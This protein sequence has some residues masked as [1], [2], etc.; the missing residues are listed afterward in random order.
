MQSHSYFRVPKARSRDPSRPGDFTLLRTWPTPRGR[1]WMR[2]TGTTETGQ[3]DAATVT[4]CLHF[5]NGRTGIVSGFEGQ[6]TLRELA[7]Y[8]TQTPVCSTA[9]VLKRSPGL[10]VLLYVGRDGSLISRVL[11]DRNDSSCYPS[12]VA[13]GARH[14]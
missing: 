8:L 2:R 14:K 1:R 11:I 3:V 10:G 7:R 13:R 9:V 5:P 6:M 12:Q 4:T